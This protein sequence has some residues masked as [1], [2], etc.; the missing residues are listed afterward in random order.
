MCC[1]NI[2]RCGGR[3]ALAGGQRLAGGQKLAGEQRRRT[4]A[5]WKAEADGRGGWREV[6]GWPRD[7]CGLKTSN[8]KMLIIL[9]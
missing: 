8:V 3:A 4:E 9:V 6:R 7:R 2:K 5:G 1:V